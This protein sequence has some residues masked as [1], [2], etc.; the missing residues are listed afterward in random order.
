ML[1]SAV[2][3]MIEDSCQTSNQLGAALYDGYLDRGHIN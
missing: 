1:N 3:G 2:Q